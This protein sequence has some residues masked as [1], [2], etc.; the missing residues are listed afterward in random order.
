MIRF[1]YSF[2]L[3]AC[4]LLYSSTT[5]QYKFGAPISPYAVGLENPNPYQTGEGREGQRAVPGFAEGAA[6]ESQRTR[7]LL[8]VM[9]FAVPLALIGVVL[10]KLHRTIKGQAQLKVLDFAESGL[11]D[12][13]TL[14]R[15]RLASAFLRNELPA[16]FVSLLDKRKPDR[17]RIPFEV[18]EHRSGLI[19]MLVDGDLDRRT[20]ILRYWNACFNDYKPDRRDHWFSRLAGEAGVDVS[21]L[22]DFN[23]KSD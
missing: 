7:D 10:F 8:E 13:D 6:P 5:E 19:Q 9:A 23:K 15:A 16:G 3:I 12:E 11:D 1:F 14:R 2:L 17:L 21:T 4:C 20:A 18:V 22:P